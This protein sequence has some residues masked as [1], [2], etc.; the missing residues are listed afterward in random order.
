MRIVFDEVRI[1][2]KRAWKENGKKRQE[3]KFFSQTI[4]PFNK[5]AQGLMKT[6]DEIMAELYTEKAEW[7]RKHEVQS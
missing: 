1:K 6:R 4:N 7:L 5:N 3:T 2:A